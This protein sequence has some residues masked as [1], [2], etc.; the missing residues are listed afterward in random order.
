VEKQIEATTR[1]RPNARTRSVD[2]EDRSDHESAGGWEEEKVEEVCGKEAEAE[3][4]DELEL[5]VNPGRVDA[6]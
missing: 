6:V 2:A 1:V 3:D 5:V 4:L